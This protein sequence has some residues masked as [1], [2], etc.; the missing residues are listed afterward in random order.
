MCRDWSVFLDDIQY[1]HISEVSGGERR[2][3]S[4]DCFVD[5]RNFECESTIEI[6][7]IIHVVANDT[8]RLRNISPFTRHWKGAVRAELS[9]NKQV[10]SRELG[11]IDLECK[12][13]GK[14]GL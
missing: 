3:C 4:S 1:T 12:T 5:S 9:S 14:N 7:V 6:N 8:D 11:S 10:S 13:R 2:L